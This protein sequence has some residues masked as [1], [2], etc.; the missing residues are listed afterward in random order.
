[1]NTRLI[2]GALIVIVGISIL[3][4]LNLF[5]FLVPLLIIWIGVQIIL[6]KDGTGNSYKQTEAQED[7]IK[8]VLIFS[9]LNQTVQ[10][11]DFAG[12]EIVTIFGGAELDLSGVKTK[13]KNVKMELVSILGSITIKVPEN[14]TVNS[15]G[16]GILGGFDNKANGGQTKKTVT[17][18]VKGVSVLGSV[19]VRN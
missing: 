3:L 11:N 8:R 13:T 16:V 12:G 14:W 6:G 15:E 10:S 9:G 2:I 18:D 19:E 1:M 5:K 7:R 17:A 4:D